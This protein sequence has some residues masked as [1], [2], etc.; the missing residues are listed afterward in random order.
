LLILSAGF[1]AWAALVLATGGTQWR[2]AGILF[3]SRDPG[4]ALA[5]GLVLF[6]C[7][8]FFFR[9]SFS[10][11]T[12]RVAAV[13]RRALPALA[14][15]CALVLGLHAVRYGTFTAGGSDSFAYVSLAYAWAN[16][17]LPRALPIPISVPW[18]SGDAS[19]A[20]LGYVLGPRPHTMVPSYAPG[21]PLMMAAA[22]LI[23]GACG[24]F[25]VVPLCAALT[26]W[27][28]FL[29]GR[30]T[31]GPW[32]G[33]L[34]AMFVVTSPIVLFQSLWPM[35]DVPAAALWTGAVLSALGGSRRSALTTG[36][37]TAAA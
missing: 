13:L 37:W 12:D 1:F 28:T 34:A 10:R 18:P 3:R 19:L 27:L 26:V 4:R 36:L 9:E 15:C 23:G 20:P 30:R 29:L 8:A 25:L 31:G 16:G 21:L 35:T 5:I 2:I 11:D 22:L 14:L 17:L 24:P 33:I 6:L 32:A 7:A